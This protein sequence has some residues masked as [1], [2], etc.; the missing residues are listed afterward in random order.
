MP[1]RYDFRIVGIP[2]AEAEEYEAIVKTKV[3]S[4]F[5]EIP[6]IVIERCHRDGISHG[7]KFPHV[8]VRC[9]L[10]TSTKITIVK[11]R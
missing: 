4:M 10:Y 3:Y 11:A 8:L 6:N 7:D 1:R 2:S 9:I 5:P